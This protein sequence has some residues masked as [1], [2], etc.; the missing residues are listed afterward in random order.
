MKKAII[1]LLGVLTVLAIALP[2]SIP[3][4]MG[5]GGNNQTAANATITNET[6][7]NETIESSPADGSHV[8]VSPCPSCSRDNLTASDTDSIDSAG[9]ITPTKGGRWLAPLH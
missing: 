4:V 2:A 7:T 1:C 5:Q 8:D 3:L 6:A 9:N